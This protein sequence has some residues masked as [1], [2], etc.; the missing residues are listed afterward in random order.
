[1]LGLS[2]NIRKELGKLFR[3][4]SCSGMSN[5]CC[6]LGDLWPSPVAGDFPALSEF[7]KEQLKKCRE[8]NKPNTKA[9]SVDLDKFMEIS[10]KFPIEVQ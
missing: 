10:E 5:M 4:C 3:N 6:N 2:H 1:M 9:D 7:A 8:L